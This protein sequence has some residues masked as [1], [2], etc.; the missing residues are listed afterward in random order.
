MAA[1]QGRENSAWRL[2]NAPNY[3]AKTAE[4][5]ITF[6]QRRHGRLV[7][8]KGLSFLRA[9]G[10]ITY[11]QG[12]SANSKPLPF[13]TREDSL[14]RHRSTEITTTLAR[15][16]TVLT[17]SRVPARLAQSACGEDSKQHQSS[18]RQSPKSI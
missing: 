3:R 17:A 15:L 10:A 18:A 6:K 13:P 11:S 14:R 16:S 5:I 1:G 8:G 2:P 4:P 9:S 12:T 7:T